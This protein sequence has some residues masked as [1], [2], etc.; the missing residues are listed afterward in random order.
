LPIYQM[1]IKKGPQRQT[2]WTDFLSEHTW[3]IKKLI[4]FRGCD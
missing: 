4:W 2:L 1:P 3:F